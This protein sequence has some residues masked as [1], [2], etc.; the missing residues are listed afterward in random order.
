MSVHS[1]AWNHFESS[2]TTRSCAAA[3]CSRKTRHTRSTS[4]A[5]SS[6]GVNVSAKQRAMHSQRR[7]RPRSSSSE[8]W[9]ASVVPATIAITERCASFIRFV[10]Q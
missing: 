3:R 9:S 10:R 4:V 6:V 5:A 2:R 7:P 8:S 1:R